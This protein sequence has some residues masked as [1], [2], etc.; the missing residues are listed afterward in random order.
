M[1]AKENFRKGALDMLILKLLSKHDCYGYQLTQIIKEQSNGLINIPSG[2]LYPSLYRLLEGN[3][4]SEYPVMV[5]KRQQRIYY[6]L[7]S[8]GRQYL[9]EQ[10]SDYYEIAEA[11]EKILQY[12]GGAKE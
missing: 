9:E 5:G 1:K 8:E 6:H 3:Y 11:I 4:I 12:D 2:S 7:E 10:M